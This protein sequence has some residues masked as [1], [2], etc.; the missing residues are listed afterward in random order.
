[1]KEFG[2]R[3]A[4]K[5]GISDSGA[6]GALVVFSD[7]I[8]MSKKKEYSKIA[9]YLRVSETI[10]YISWIVVGQDVTRNGERSNISLDFFV[11]PDLA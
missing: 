10:G 2:V 11:D 3:I 1:M 5:F 6:H 4:N 9:F 7:F 8:D